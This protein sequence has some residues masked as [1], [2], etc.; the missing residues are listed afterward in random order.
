[1]QMPHDAPEGRASGRRFDRWVERG[2]EIYLRMKENGVAFLLQDGYPPGA[3]PVS[4]QDQ[5][6]QLTA[7]KLSGDPR[8]HNS[9]RAQQALADLE[10]EAARHIPMRPGGM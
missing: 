7:W 5:R 8:Y 2:Q 1:M 9:P 10:R 6:V 3:E 4:P